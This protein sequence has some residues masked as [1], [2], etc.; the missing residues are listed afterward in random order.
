M[1]RDLNLNDLLILE[2]YAKFDFPKID[3][4]LFCIKK[5]VEI[6]GKLIGLFLTHLT[7]E[8]SLVFDDR[9]SR[10]TRARA[11][12]EIYFHLFKELT[13]SGFDDAHIFLKDDLVSYGEMLKKHCGFED[14]VGH[15]LVLRRRSG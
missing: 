2:K 3:S 4:P 9:V 13:K 6:D 10:I 7:T 14:I 1:V 12:K 15:G 11:L 5:A 8:V